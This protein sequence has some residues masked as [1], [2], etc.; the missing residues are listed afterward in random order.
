MLADQQLSIFD[1][2][3]Q[4][5]I[6]EQPVQKNFISISRENTTAL[7]KDVRSSGQLNRNVAFDVGQKIGG[8]RKD[9]S[10]QREDFLA[11]PSVELLEGI[12]NTD[13]GTAAS[14]IIRDTFFSWFSYEDCKAR[15]VVPGV[16]KALQLIINRIPKESKD[17]AEDRRKYVKSMLFLSDI[18]ST[19]TTEEEYSL[20]EKR[21]ITVMFGS[22]NVEFMERRIEAKK[23]EMN[24]DIT[25]A[26]RASLLLEIENYIATLFMCELDDSMALYDYKGP[27]KNYFTKHQSRVSVLHNAYAI[28]H[29]DELLPPVTAKKSVGKTAKRQPV[30][31]RILPESPTRVGGT[32]VLIDNP[33][34]YVDHFNFRGSQFGHY[35]NDEVGQGHLLRSAEAYTDLAEILNIPIKAISLKGELAMAFGARGRGSA[36]GHYEPARKVI[37]LTKEKGSLGILAHEWFHS[38]DHYLYNVSYSFQNGKVGF[39]TD[40]E[41]G[42]LP[43]EVTDA[44]DTLIKAIKIGKSNA[45]Y[46]VRNNNNSYSINS[47]FIAMYNEVEGDLHK[48]M[49]KRLENFDAR[50]ERNLAGCVSESYKEKAEAK[51]AKQRV[52]EIRS[53][54]KAVSEYHLKETGEEVHLVPYTVDR[55]TYYQHAIHMDKGSIGKYWSS[56]IELAARAFESYIFEEL[57]ERQ[58]ISDYLVCGIRD[59]VFPQGEERFV[60]YEA[61]S[62]FVDSIRTY[63]SE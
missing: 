48:F 43:H 46:D 34:H 51:Y 23:A 60:I 7:V 5:P 26:K 56:N 40:Q 53:T 42:V 8:A 57:K 36:L 6:Q 2:P 35:V 17:G 38:L 14:L 59:S 11:K 25:P 55:S 10:R 19:V 33:K 18:L 31:Q 50:V 49:D 24:E 32:P 29:W 1:M 22:N 58:M 52:Q 30:W 44:L 9:L 28:K 45:Y 37:N 63:L 13:V 54:A 47:S 3:I 21:V 62:A 27:F 41:H 20:F 61:M 4:E 12:E 15:G 39:L 16:A